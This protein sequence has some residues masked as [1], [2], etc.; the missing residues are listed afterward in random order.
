MAFFEV[1]AVATCRGY[2]DEMLSLARAIPR[3]TSIEPPIVASDV[4]AALRRFRD[5]NASQSSEGTKKAPLHFAVVE[6]AV[7]DAF[8]ALLV[9]HHSS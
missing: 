6:T 4:E 3:T 9:G 7:R 1:E 5:F 2:L 8:V